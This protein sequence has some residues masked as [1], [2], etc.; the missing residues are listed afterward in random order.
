MSK[1][2]SLGMKFKPRA[3]VSTFSSPL[4]LT[5]DSLVSAPHR[6][7]G[8]TVLRYFINE[9]F[10]KRSR[11]LPPAVVDH[12]QVKQVEVPKKRNFCDCGLYLIHAFKIFFEHPDQILDWIQ[13][14]QL[15]VITLSF[16]PI[17]IFHF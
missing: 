7:Q 8:K 14:C 12:V 11:E 16:F 10:A 15:N 2:Q 4:I 3:D 1:S 5:L 9:A 17:L 13:V 6:A